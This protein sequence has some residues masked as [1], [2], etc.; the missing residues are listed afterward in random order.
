MKNVKQTGL[1]VEAPR[2]TDYIMGAETAIKYEER[3]PTGYWGA[4]LPTFEKQHG[5]TFDTMSCVTF[6]A[7]N[8]IEIQVKWLIENKKFSPEQLQT[9]KDLGFFDANG[10]F[11]ISDRFTAIM[12]GTTKQGNTFHKVWDS[13]RNYGILPESDFPFGGTTFEQYHDPKNITEAMKEKA[14]KSIEIFQFNYEWVF[15]DNDPR[16]TEDQSAQAELALRQSPIQ[17]G[18]PLPAGHAVTMYGMI[19]NISTQILDHYGSFV[20]DYD[21]K[22]AIHFGMKGYVT[23]KKPVTPP[24]Y[25]VYIF[26]RKLVK[27]IRRDVDVKILK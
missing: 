21:W 22:N 4:Y 3:I 9:I 18:I 11:N 13:I 2:P 8:V 20:Y 26:T 19:E 24:K 12:S 6:S 7:T 16:F 15:F 10:N 1:L 5:M 14:L 23:V 27:G 17:I 25:P